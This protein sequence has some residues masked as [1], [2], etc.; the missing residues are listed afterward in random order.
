MTVFYLLAVDLPSW[1]LGIDD[2]SL[3]C[4]VQY[5]SF[6]I[7]RV[8]GPHLPGDEG[9]GMSQDHE[10]HNPLYRSSFYILHQLSANHVLRRRLQSPLIS[11]KGPRCIDGGRADPRARTLSPPRGGGRPHIWGQIRTRQPDD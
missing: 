2:R 9:E 10:A 1:V 8:G 11:A 7:S 3:S 5:L 6:F 4:C